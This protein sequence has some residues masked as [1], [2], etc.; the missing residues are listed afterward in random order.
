[1]KQLL[2]LTLI[3]LIGW[4]TIFSVKLL[5]KPAPIFH[6]GEHISVSIAI[7]DIA[8][9]VSIKALFANK[10][11]S[12]VLEKFSLDKTQYLTFEVYDT[13]PD[14]QAFG[15]YTLKEIVL[16]FGDRRTILTS[17]VDFPKYKIEI[18]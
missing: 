15:K 4:L 14:N 18:K 13:I 8:P 17:P 11:D 12:F 16:D 2:Y 3:L 7:A 6:R 1:M 10:K 5:A 9:P